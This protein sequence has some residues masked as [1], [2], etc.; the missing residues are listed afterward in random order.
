MTEASQLDVDPMQNSEFNKEIEIFLEL[1]SIAPCEILLTG[2]G[3]PIAH[4]E[5]S[6]KLVR[7]QY[8]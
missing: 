4:K 1:M 5:S 6:D 8:L 7:K 3:A 2:A